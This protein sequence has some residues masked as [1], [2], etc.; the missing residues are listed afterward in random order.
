MSTHGPYDVQTVKRGN[1][2]SGFDVRVG[3][4]IMFLLTVALL[5]IW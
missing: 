1:L 3:L 4:V 2:V 5:P